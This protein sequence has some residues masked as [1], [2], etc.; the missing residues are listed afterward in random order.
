MATPA[1]RIEPEL[2]SQEPR[3]LEE[4]ALQI[5]QQKSFLA[6]LRA[7][8]D[9]EL[10]KH[11]EQL[12]RQYHV[13]E[14]AGLADDVYR[15][16]AHEPPVQ[17][18]W[19]RAS[20]HPELLRQAG[21]DW[22]D[23]QIREY[24]QPNDSNFRAEIYLPDPLVFGPNAKPV[25][26]YKGSNGPVMALDDFGNPA[27][28]ESAPEDWLN[29]GVQ[30]VG[31]E[32]DYYNRAMELANNLKRSRVEDKFEIVGHSLGGGLASAA[33]AVTGVPATTINSA[34]LHTNTARRY[35]ESNGLTVFDTQQTVT[36]IQIQGE[37]LT[38]VQVGVA[39]LSDVRRMQ[40]G[41]VANMAAD[42][43]RLPGA[44]ERVEDLIAQS[45]PH[46][47][48]AQQD[49]LGLIDYL[50]E[51]SG[52]QILQRVP[53]AAGQ[54]QPTL[55]AKMRDTNGNLVDRPAELTLGD[56]GKDAGPLLNVLTGAL[57]GA[58]AG[59]Y[60]GGAIA[61]GG[62]VTEV[63]L[64][65]IGDGYQVTGK[66]AGQTAELGVQTVGQVAG[67]QIRQGGEAVAQVRLATGYVG[68]VLPMVQCAG[69]QW[70][71][72]TTNGLL[73]AVDK[74]PFA[75]RLFPGID[76]LVERRERATDAF[77]EDKRE[78]AAH[79][80][81][82]ARQDAQGIRG[83]ADQSARGIR[84]SANIVGADLR[85]ANEQAGLKVDLAFDE[86]GRSIRGVS[87]QAP[88]VLATGGAV[89]GTLGAAHVTFLS[90][91]PAGLI[92]LAKTGVV[93]TEG[94]DAAAEAVSRHGMT[95]TV[96][97]SLDA[98]TMTLEHE[99]IE[100]LARS[101]ALQERLKPATESHQQMSS[102][103][104]G[105]SDT[106][107]TIGLLLNQPNHPDYSL[108]RGAAEG[109][110]ALDA[111]AHRV[112]DL[113]S[114]QL[115]GH[116]AVAAKREGLS[117]IDHVILSQDA[118]RTFAVQGR[119]DDPAHQRAAVDTTQGLNTPLA[120]STRQMAEVGHQ[121]ADKARTQTL[122]QQQE[123]ETAS[124]ALRFA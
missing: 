21:V 19:R 20:E 107:I 122:S 37:V 40:L 7:S 84:Q 108:F 120:Q 47:T 41:L 111:R 5:R 90:N 25:I 17:L 57:V 103:G 1:V 97:P 99:A 82:A 71:N 22:S 26:G 121:H 14:M 70:S 50:A 66:I 32:S 53:T 116:L 38:D 106:P 105:V 85:R 86:A 18:G 9:P 51:N 69:A 42:V 89:V 46:S 78:Q 124:R 58:Q 54:V 60:A 92:N 115:S 91:G 12:E 100:Q 29:N 8:A 34:G 80:I 44:R 23:E 30:G 48:R 73:R 76:Q 35:A 81:D 67:W 27:L 113:R 101:R 96:I 52:N 31:L 118:S 123:Q 28:R 87:G 64:D 63:V 68:A 43:S 119:L 59:K 114:D 109:V 65:K 2:P 117:A 75:D 102:S 74:I 3:S 79:N 16:A 88:T 93:V 24:L 72:E 11:A 15:S 49:A 45:F 13:R 61:E 55:P 104:A 62:R 110:Y 95:S 39:Q 56:V 10:A 36:A 98:R 4:K 77:C 94:K 112:P 83:W 33:S 6:N